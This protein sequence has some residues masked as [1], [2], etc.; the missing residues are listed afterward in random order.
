MSPD[1]AAD[2]GA[3]WFALASS[4]REAAALWLA[5]GRAEDALA[6][7]SRSLVQHGALV[8]ASWDSDDA[9]PPPPPPPRD[10]PHQ[11]SADDDSALDSVVSDLDDLDARLARLRGRRAAARAP[12]PPVVETAR[13]PQPPSSNPVPKIERTNRD[14]LDF[15]ETSSGPSRTPKQQPASPARRVVATEKILGE[16]PARRRRKP[17]A[18][19][20]APP[21]T[22]PV[23]APSARSVDRDRRQRIAKLRR[24]RAELSPAGF[25]ATLRG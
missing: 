21:S 4:R 20:S 5:V 2:L 9:G 19:G 15:L 1:R 7:S 24:D 23:P 22:A 17:M 6:A 12:P 14:V 18:V 25:P 13:P 8:A 10:R 16:A 11:P 3:P